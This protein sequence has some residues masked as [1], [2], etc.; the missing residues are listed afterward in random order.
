MTGKHIIAAGFKAGPIVGVV[1]DALLEAQHAGEFTDVEGAL[2]WLGAHLAR[3]QA[4]DVSTL[5]KPKL[6]NGSKHCC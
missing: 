3:F 4:I 5:S 6:A 1:K 2:A